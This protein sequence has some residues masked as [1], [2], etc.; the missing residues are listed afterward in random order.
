MAVALCHPSCPTTGELYL[1]GGGWYARAAVGLTPG[2][3]D[4]AGTATAEDLLERWDEVQGGELTEPGDAMGVG[5]LLYE[6]QGR[7]DG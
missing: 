3:F 4:E 5:R 6:K 1:A 2:W 7:G